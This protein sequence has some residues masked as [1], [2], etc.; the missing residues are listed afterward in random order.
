VT[1]D[2]WNA[3]KMLLLAE[4]SAA[5]DTNKSI[6]KRVHDLELEQRAMTTRMRLYITIAVIILSPVWAYAVAALL[7][8]CFGQ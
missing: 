3:Y 8:F 7:R 2:D 5:K 6:E 1:Q 4:I